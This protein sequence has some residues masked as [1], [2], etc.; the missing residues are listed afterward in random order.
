M[1]KF[2]ALISFVSIKSFPCALYASAPKLPWVKSSMQTVKLG[3]I[4]GPVPHSRTLEFQIAWRAWLGLVPI[5][6]ADF[7][8]LR[9]SSPREHVRP[10]LSHLGF[11]KCQRPGS[12]L[13][14]AVVQEA[15]AGA[16]EH[17]RRLQPTRPIWSDAFSRT[18][19][20]AGS[21]PV[22]QPSRRSVREIWR[23]F[24]LRNPDFRVFVERAFSPC[25]D[26]C[27]YL[28]RC[29]RLV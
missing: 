9:R 11:S 15:G 2:T 5:A 1:T 10:A 25:Q 12:R 29:P 24:Q 18:Q 28:G 19:P 27:V 4:N 22:W 21:R 17:G 23:P 14:R 6:P 26:F 16:K 7:M 20:R 13:L 8:V 3:I